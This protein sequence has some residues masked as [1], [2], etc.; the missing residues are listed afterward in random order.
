M[1]EYTAKLG[2]RLAPE[3]FIRIWQQ[4]RSLSEVAE[5]V[6]KPRSVCYSRA[7]YYRSHGVPLQ[8]LSK[9]IDAW[10]K[11]IALAESLSLQEPPA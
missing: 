1:T 3:E 10:P 4:A 6:G 9:R 2:A 7:R 5:K 8:P 11:L